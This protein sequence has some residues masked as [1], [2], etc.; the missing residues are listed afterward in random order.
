MFLGNLYL[1]VST[2]IWSWGKQ[3][4]INMTSSNSKTL[5]GY[6]NQMWINNIFL[7]ICNNDKT[8]GSLLRAD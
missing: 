5:V 1:W 3:N 8:Y 7:S 4:I 6:S 2:T